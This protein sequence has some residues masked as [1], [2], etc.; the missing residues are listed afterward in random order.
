MDGRSVKILSLLAPALLALLLSTQVTAQGGRCG[1]ERDVPAK[2]LDELTWKQLN[3]V[4]EDV[5]EDKFDSAYD[6]YRGVIIY[7]RMFDGSISVGDKVRMVG[8][9]KEYVINGLG[10]F[11]PAAVD[12]KTLGAGEVGFLSAAIRS[13]SDIGVCAYQSH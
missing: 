3:R 5:G 8:T 12:V 4:Y 6:D 13:I 9:E 10:K 1:V 11:T 7:I 2:A